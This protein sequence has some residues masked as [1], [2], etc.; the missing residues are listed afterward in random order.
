M[1]ASNHCTRTIRGVVAYAN[2]HVPDLGSSGVPF[3]LLPIISIGL[4][5][6][7]FPIV[8]ARPANVYVAL[9]FSQMTY[10]EK[11]LISWVGLRGAVPIILASLPL[12]ARVSKAEMIL[13]IVVHRTY[14]SPSPG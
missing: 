6:A 9:A 2:H 14:V 11:A 7:L 5:V 8:I 10:R 13:H 3:R 12:V 1:P 4:F